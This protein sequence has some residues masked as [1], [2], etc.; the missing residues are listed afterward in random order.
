MSGGFGVLPRPTGGGSVERTVY[1][2]GPESGAYD[3]EWADAQN[4]A[5]APSYGGPYVPQI[6]VEGN[7]AHISGF[8]EMTGDAETFAMTLPVALRPVHHVWR[9][10]V[11]FDASGAEWVEQNLVG[12]F[13]L[14]TAG[15]LTVVAEISLAVGDTIALD[16]TWLLAE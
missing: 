6:I 14:D 3:V 7:T 11:V 13:V 5:A 9:P 16:G 2:L 4:A 10:V 1:T 8:I 12:Q 15:G